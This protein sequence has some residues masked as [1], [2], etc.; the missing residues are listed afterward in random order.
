MQ[1]TPVLKDVCFSLQ[2]KELER[3]GPGMKAVERL[4]GGISMMGVG[5]ADNKP[6]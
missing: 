2:T 4:T 3:D 6:C 5:S 1:I